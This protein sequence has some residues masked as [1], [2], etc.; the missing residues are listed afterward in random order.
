MNEGIH[1]APETRSE[2]LKGSLSDWWDKIPFPAWVPTIITAG[3]VLVTGALGFIVASWI[4]RAV[5]TVVSLPMPWSLILA[6]VIVGILVRLTRE[7]SRAVRTVR[8]WWLSL[9]SWSRNWFA[10]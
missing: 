1:P 2:R 7:A 3:A 10:R 5:V 8:A 4:V 6:S 9:N